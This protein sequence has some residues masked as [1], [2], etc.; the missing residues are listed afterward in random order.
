[1]FSCS[2]SPLPPPNVNCGWFTGI[3]F[4]KGSGWACVPVVPVGDKMLTEVLNSSTPNVT[5]QYH[6][7][8]RA[9]NHCPE[10][11]KQVRLAAPY[12][13]IGTTDSSLSSTPAT[14]IPRFSKYALY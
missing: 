9:G 6:E 1:M 12:G 2:S 11:V 14:I 10:M 5:S 13:T 4:E 3:E 8:A 7:N